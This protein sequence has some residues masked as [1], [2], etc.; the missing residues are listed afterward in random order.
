MV[1]VSAGARLHVGFQNLSLTHE[2]LYGGIGVGLAEP[3]VRVGASRADAVSA[4]DEVTR[5]YAERA[6]SVLSVA[7]VDVS[8]ERRL[9]AHVGLGSGTQLALAIYAATAHAYDLEPRV[10]EH[11]PELGRGGRSGVGVATFEAGGF[12]VDG[13]H[14]TSRFT[15]EPP[16]TGEWNVP[17]VVARH[18][19]PADWRFVVALPAAETGR[20]GDAEDDSIRRVVESGDPATADEIAGVLTRRLLPAAAEGRLDAFGD[21]IGRIGRLNGS[22][23]AETQGGLYRP[24]AGRLVDALESGSVLSG[25]GQ[26]SWGP[27]VYGVTDEARAAEAAADARRVLDELGLEGSVLVSEPARSGARVDS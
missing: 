21:A 8:V 25:L 1:T 17:P 27:A 14:P 13:G 10:R 19:L 16:A 24:P 15:A 7:G 23:Y 22:W 20:S 6:V 11:A 2:R 5:R 18:D 4:P 12:V 3:R 26:S 9:P